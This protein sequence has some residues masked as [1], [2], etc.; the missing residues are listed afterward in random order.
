MKCL[1]EKNMYIKQCKSNASNDMLFVLCWVW[2]IRSAIKWS[3]KAN[4]WSAQYR[5]QL[6]RCLDISSYEQILTVVS[7]DGYTFLQT[8]RYILNIHS[9]SSYWFTIDAIAITVVSFNVYITNDYRKRNGNIRIVNMPAF[10]L[11]IQKGKN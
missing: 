10:F 5:H 7:F 4:M 2:G 8:K 1:V 6:T 11:L 3:A 9:V